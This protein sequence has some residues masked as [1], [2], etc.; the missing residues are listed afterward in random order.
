M[1]T[2]DSIR[3]IKEPVRSGDVVKM[4][5]NKP[6]VKIVMRAPV[7]AFLRLEV[8]VGERGR[9][10]VGCVVDNDSGVATL[11]ATRLAC[12]ATRVARLAPEHVYGVEGS[13]AEAELPDSQPT[14]RED[15]PA[16]GA[17][18]DDL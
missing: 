2:H 12:G 8:S 10:T 7:Y 18:P 6:D 11:L 4:H 16:G 9:R 14:D 13:S 5:G 15:R 17:N 3:P 1:A